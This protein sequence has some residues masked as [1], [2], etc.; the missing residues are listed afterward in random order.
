MWYLQY[1]ANVQHHMVNPMANTILCAQTAPIVETTVFVATTMCMWQYYTGDG[2]LPHL[3][4]SIQHNTTIDS[5]G[6][7]LARNAWSTIRCNSG[8]H[9]TVAHFAKP[10]NTTNPH[11]ATHSDKN[12]RLQYGTFAWRWPVLPSQQT[13]PP[14]SSHTPGT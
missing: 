10:I 8:H 9:R 7:P 6:R 12:Y 2:L 13:P 1:Y 5:T 11:N 4:D 3:R 14:T